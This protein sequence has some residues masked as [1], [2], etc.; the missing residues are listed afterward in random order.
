MPSS[1][2]ESDEKHHS[3]HH[4]HHHHKHHHK[5]KDKHK[6]H[7]KHS[8]RPHRR[9]S[10]SGSS[11]ESSPER[12]PNDPV[13]GPQ[14]NP[15]PLPPPPDPDYPS[16]GPHAG[17][18]PES[19][20]EKDAF[21]PELVAASLYKSMK[22]LGTDEKCII[23]ELTSHTNDQLQLVKEKY[24]ILYGKTLKEDLKSDLSF[25]FKDVCV[26]LLEPTREYEAHKL[27]NAIKGLGTDEMCVIDILCTKDGSELYKL[28]EVYKKCNYFGIIIFY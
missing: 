21:N 9:H 11:R 10:K 14:P 18:D 22:G 16:N 6:H 28:N 27:K 15:D 24:F 17:P 20:G 5:H 2:S 8:P 3:H 26:G 25:H 23:N 4:H 1:S 12:I 13:P 19:D 7:H